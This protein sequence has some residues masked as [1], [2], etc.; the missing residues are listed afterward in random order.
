MPVEPLPE[1]LAETPAEALVETLATGAVVPFEPVP[2]IAAVAIEP[3]FPAPLEKPGKPRVGFTDGQL[4]SMVRARQEPSAWVGL[5]RRRAP[6]RTGGS[7]ES[8]SLHLR[9]LVPPLVFRAG[10]ASRVLLGVLA[11]LL[12]VVATG[13]IARALR[14]DRGDERDSDPLAI[15]PD[16]DLAEIDTDA[17]LADGAYRILPVFTASANLCLGEGP[18]FRTSGK[19]AVVTHNCAT[20][21]PTLSWL[22]HQPSGRYRILWRYPDARIGCFTVNPNSD[23]YVVTSQSCGT[24]PGDQEFDLELVETTMG[25]AASVDLPRVKLYVPGVPNGCLGIIDGD[26][27]P[28]AVLVSQR[29]DGSAEQQFVFM[30]S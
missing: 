23:G 11:L 5:H 14:P 30:K 10:W 18:Q 26:T 4:A 7:A 9:D 3:V 28:G 6:F 13:G 12:V 24:A 29:C 8:G 20:A 25:R 27:R 21:T 2:G 17:L 15:V 1:T 19:A 16:G 22:E